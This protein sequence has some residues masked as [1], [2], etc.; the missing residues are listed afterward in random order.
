M[1]QILQV[2]RLKGK[3]QVELATCL[4]QVSLSIARNKSVFPFLQQ[5]QNT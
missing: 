5:R 1:I 4:D 3:A 2:A